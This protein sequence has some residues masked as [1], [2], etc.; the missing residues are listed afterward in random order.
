MYASMYS[1]ITKDY[2]CIRSLKLGN[3]IN[4]ITSVNQWHMVKKHQ[5]RNQQIMSLDIR[6]TK[7]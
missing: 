7:W 6:G 1:L 4:T 3:D 2:V 5:R